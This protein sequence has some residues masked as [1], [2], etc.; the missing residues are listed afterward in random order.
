MSLRDDMAADLAGIVADADGLGEVCVLTVPA[1]TSTVSFRAVIASP[2]LKQPGEKHAVTSDGEE[3]TARCILA[4]IAAGILAATGTSRMPGMGDTLTARGVTW[5]VTAA[6]PTA[7]GGCL[8]SMTSR[9]AVSLGSA[10]GS[11]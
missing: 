6:R 4:D 10:W 5:A 3:S 7:G 11:A 9:R 1:G 2:S 8:I